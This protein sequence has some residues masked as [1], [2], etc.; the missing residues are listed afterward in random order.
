MK[1]VSAWQR[2]MCDLSG[3]INIIAGNIK[4]KHNY[5][6][7]LF[8]VYMN[9]QIFIPG[10]DKWEER[11]LK[12]HF[13]FIRGGLISTQP[14]GLNY[15]GHLVEWRGR[16]RLALCVYLLKPRGRGRLW[17][18]WWWSCLELYIII[19]LIAGHVWLQLCFVL[20]YY[21]RNDKKHTH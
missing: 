14:L 13:L 11:N 10:I 9:K 6:L 3:I 1:R 18:G 19:E 12:L 16:R 21:T 15:H 7:L 20:A 8:V 17:C 5:K 4:G 2:G